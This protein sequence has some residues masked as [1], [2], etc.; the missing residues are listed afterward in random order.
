MEDYNVPPS[1]W[2]ILNDGVFN[3]DIPRM[4]NYR[5]AIDN[6]FVYEK[7]FVQWGPVEKQFIAAG[8]YFY[9]K[10]TADNNF[11]KQ[12]YDGH[13]DSF[14]EI[15]KLAKLLLTENLKNKSNKQLFRIYN[16]THTV[17]AKCWIWGAIIMF[18]DMSSVKISDRV[19]LEIEDKLKRL[20]NPEIVFSKLITPLKENELSKEIL[21]VLKLASK[22]QNN[23]QLLQEFKNSNNLTELPADVRSN[24][25]KLAKQFGWLQYYYIGPAAGPAYYYDLIKKRMQRNADTEIE[26]RNKGAIELRKF[27]KRCEALLSQDELQKIDML[28]E[29]AHLKEARKETQ[30]YYLNL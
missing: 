19:K 6:L 21:A 25:K 26:A 9:R 1:P 18:M 24:I 5:L 14:K 22:I 16:D 20:G 3:I 15:K 8:D 12:I 30:T 28:R 4:S 29:F 23:K 11:L 2:Y 10:I 7:D 27:H 17:F 13:Y